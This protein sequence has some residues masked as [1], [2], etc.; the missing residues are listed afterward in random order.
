M[1]EA[2]FVGHVAAHKL[3]RLTF[4]ILVLQKFGLDLQNNI[5]LLYFVQFELALALTALKLPERRH[6]LF[7]HFLRGLVLVFERE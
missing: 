7:R 4:L 6:L 5:C 2:P 3:A 1:F